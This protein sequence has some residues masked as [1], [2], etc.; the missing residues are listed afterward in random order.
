M[1]VYSSRVGFFV[2]LG[3]IGVC[4]RWVI[5]DIGLCIIE[6]FCEVI[7]FFKDIEVSKG[8]GFGFGKGLVRVIRGLRG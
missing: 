8:D 4:G 5:G 7:C 6:V 1:G 2:F 3:L